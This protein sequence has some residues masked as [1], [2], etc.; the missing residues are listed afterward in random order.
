MLA[1]D[2]SVL[3]L[4]IG[5]GLWLGATPLPLIGAGWLAVAGSVAAHAVVELGRTP[6]AGDTRGGVG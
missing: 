3:H 4:G 2:P 1:L 5:G 6:P